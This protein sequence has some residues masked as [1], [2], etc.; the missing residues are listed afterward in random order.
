[1]NVD[2]VSSRDGGSHAGEFERVDRCEFC[3]IQNG[4]EEAVSNNRAMWEATENLAALAGS[5]VK[6]KVPNSSGA[7]EPLSRSRI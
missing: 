7:K 2:S 1:L 3:A 4:R 5:L 6:R